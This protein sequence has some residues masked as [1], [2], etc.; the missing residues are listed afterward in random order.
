[1][2]PPKFAMHLYSGYR[3]QAGM[4]LVLLWAWRRGRRKAGTHKTNK[5]AESR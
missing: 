3:N 5:I 1:M 2:G 4:P